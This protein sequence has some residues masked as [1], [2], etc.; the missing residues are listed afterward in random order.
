MTPRKPKPAEEPVVT[1]TADEAPRKRPGRVASPLTN[2]LQEF[3]VAK[4]KLDVANKRLSKVE[5]VQEQLEAAQ[6]RYDAAKEALDDVY[7]DLTA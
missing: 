7:A 1:E 6:A 5:T 4:H 3:R 2:A